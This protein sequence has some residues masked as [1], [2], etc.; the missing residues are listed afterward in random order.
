MNTIYFRFTKEAGLVD[1]RAVHCN[2]DTVDLGGKSY[3]E[4][5]H[6]PC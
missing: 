6:V 4:V 2:L 3:D 5:G 1:T